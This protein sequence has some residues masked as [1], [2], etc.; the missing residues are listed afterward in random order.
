MPKV[1][2]AGPMRG[3]PQL[4]FPAFDKARELG[5]T[6]GWSVVSPAD[7]DR[8]AGISESKYPK[9]ESPAFGSPQVR[10]FMR[11]DA[12]VLIEVLK[13][14]DGD[15]IAVLPGWENSTGAKAEVALALWGGVRVL[16]AETFYPIEVELK[17]A[18]FRPPLG[19]GSC[20]SGMCGVT[21]HVIE[22][23]DRI[24]NQPIQED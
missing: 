15:A 13:A 4:N 11:R 1:Y 6:L 21:Y 24:A 19:Y 10:E 23:A 12:N 14:E 16:D 18:T 8:D 9:G 5:Q 3:K 22:T 17:G 2:I 7:M 20:A